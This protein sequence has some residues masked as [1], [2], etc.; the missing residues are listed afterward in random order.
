MGLPNG[1]GYLGQRDFGP[2]SCVNHQMHLPVFEE[3][4]RRC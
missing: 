4:Y 2:L 1:N 3:I